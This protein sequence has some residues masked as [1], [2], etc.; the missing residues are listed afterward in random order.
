MLPLK[1]T[2]LCVMHLA[3]A[4]CHANGRNSFLASTESPVR[5]SY[6]WRREMKRLDLHLHLSLTFCQKYAVCQISYARKLGFFLKKKK[7]NHHSAL[8]RLLYGATVSRAKVSHPRA[9]RVFQQ[10]PNRTSGLNW[11]TGQVD[12]TDI[13]NFCSFFE[14]L[15]L[16]L[17]LLAF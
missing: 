13:Y 5:L 1:K 11:K 2:P 4:I 6:M 3:N 9:S 10:I 17:I 7:Q 12:I 8:P 15:R 14:E 16:F